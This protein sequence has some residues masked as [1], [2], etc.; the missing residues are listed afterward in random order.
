MPVAYT[1]IELLLKNVGLDDKYTTLDIL[2]EY[3]KVYMLQHEKGNVRTEVTKTAESLG[4]KTGLHLFPK[5]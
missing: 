3:S 2:K 5:T 4:R 1:K